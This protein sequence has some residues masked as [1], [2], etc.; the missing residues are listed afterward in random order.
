VIRQ[1]IAND[2]SVAGRKTDIR[3]APLLAE[4][5]LYFQSISRHHQNQLRIIVSIDHHRHTLKL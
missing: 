1:N 4:K 5:I 2:V 3:L